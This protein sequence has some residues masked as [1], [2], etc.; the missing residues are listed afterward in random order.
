[1]IKLV[2][3]LAVK[4]DLELGHGTVVQQ[5]DINGNGLEDV[6]YDK[7]N[8]GNI[9][10]LSSSLQES[11]TQVELDAK[12]DKNEAST[13]YAL[14]AGDATQVF[15][16]EE[17]FLN[18]HAV[19][20][21]HLTTYVAGLLSDYA[22]ITN[23][24]T[25]TNIVQYI[26]TTDYHPAT[27][28]Y[29]DDTVVAIGAGDM[30]KSIYD[31]LDNGV[32]N[33]ARLLDGT[34]KTELMRYVGIAS[35]CDN[36][37]TVGYWEGEDITN[38]PVI[39]KGILEVYS[40]TSFGQVT[41]VYHTSDGVTYERSFDVAWSTW[42]TSADSIT[43]QNDLLGN[44]DTVNVALSAEQGKV[45]ADNISSISDT[46]VPV[47]GIIMYSGAFSSIPT[48]WAICDGLNGTPNL[49][50]RFIMGT[51]TEGN[52]GDEGGTEEST[53]PSHSH[54]ANHNH[55]ASSYGAGSHSH[56]IRYSQDAAYG[57]DHTTLDYEVSPSKGLDYCDEDGYHSHSIV[58]N[59]KTMST[60]TAVV[61]GDNRPPY[62]TLA[63]IIRKA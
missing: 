6:T 44:I 46:S 10:A 7:I 33:D 22:L 50:D 57:T 36:H 27:K 43:V 14:L 24:L 52:V 9:P 23:V 32:V 60:G 4:Q 26:P 13:L 59:T 48:S 51:A 42:F 11:T 25:K 40:G 56:G 45:L 63:Y 39:G 15:S 1:M 16:V 8:A 49:V 29:V 5:R 54:T 34:P 53:M 18:D 30:A 19:S 47:G 20:K 62:Y 21:I 12:L 61:A 35:D 58:V 38:A 2:K 28:K 3:E 55:S 41:Q 31:S 37:I 17:P